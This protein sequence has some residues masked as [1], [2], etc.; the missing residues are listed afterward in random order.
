MDKVEVRFYF[1]RCPVCGKVVLGFS[2]G[3]VIQ[4]ALSHLSSRHGIVKSGGDLDVREGV[5]FVE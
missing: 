3:Q 2:K 5:G 4:N 1:W